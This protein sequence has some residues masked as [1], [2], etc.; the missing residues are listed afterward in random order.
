MMA[1]LMGPLSGVWKED[2]LVFCLVVVLGVMLVVDLGRYWVVR[3]VLKT[4][5]LLVPL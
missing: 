4:V 5:L 2:Q 1:K 3:S